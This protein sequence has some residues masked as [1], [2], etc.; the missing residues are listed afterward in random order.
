MQHVAVQ[1]PAGVDAAQNAINADKWVAPSMEQIR[2]TAKANAALFMKNL[3]V[4][5]S[6]TSE[7]I[8]NQESTNMGVTLIMTSAQNLDGESSQ[9]PTVVI[10]GSKG[11]ITGTIPSLPLPGKTL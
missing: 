9:M 2:A 11:T 3:H 4:K 6:T 10:K 1:P 8:K 7:I 5:L